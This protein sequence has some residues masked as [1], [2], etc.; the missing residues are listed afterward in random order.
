MKARLQ[1][2]KASTAHYAR[3][4]AQEAVALLRRRKFSY[5]ALALTLTAGSLYL[6]GSRPNFMTSGGQVAGPSIDSRSTGPSQAAPL[7]AAAGQS[8]PPADGSAPAQ[9][10][11]GSSQ[12][13]TSVTVNGTDIPVPDNGEVNTT[14]PSDGG[15]ASVSVSHSS[16]GDSSYSSLNVQIS[17]Q[18]TA[19]GEGN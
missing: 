4:V 2:A 6:V 19:S 5:A 15:S 18:S 12:S 11:A 13:H 10:S 9:S 8:S 3:I 14:V 16:S 7:Q 1:A 17:S